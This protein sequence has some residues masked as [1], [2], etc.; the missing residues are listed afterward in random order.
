MNQESERPSETQLALTH[1]EAGVR[2][3]HQN[4]ERTFFEWLDRIACVDK[5]AWEGPDGLVVRLNR[6]PNDDDLREIIALF[7]RFGVN[8]RQLARFE[9]PENA[10]WFR[11]PD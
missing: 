10:G 9:T 1:V 11:N 5:Y 8:M 3:Y 2:F 6:A 7:Q 4:D